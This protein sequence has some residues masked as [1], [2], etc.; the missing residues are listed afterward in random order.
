[1]SV[2]VV[3]VTCPSCG[4]TVLVDRPSQP[5]EL[6]P[7][8]YHWPHDEQQSSAAVFFPCPGGDVR[9]ARP[10][11]LAPIGDIGLAAPGTTS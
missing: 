9:D 5:F 2:R 7:A 1:M 3:I 11:D 10:A 4:R 8:A 6:N